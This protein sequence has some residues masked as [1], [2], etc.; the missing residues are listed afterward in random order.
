MKKF[1]AILL[2]LISG[3]ASYRTAEATCH[4]GEP[5][6]TLTG[7][8]AVASFWTGSQTY[9]QTVMQCEVDADDKAKNCKIQHDYTLDD[10]VNA[11]LESEKLTYAFSQKQQDS[12][13]QD[14]AKL[15]DIAKREN[16]ALFKCAAGLKDASKTLKRISGEK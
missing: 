12:C 2:V 10:A 8:Q 3:C 7:G 13:W 14:Y 4:P 5:C 1:A 9:G 16:V 15:N 11:I 6:I